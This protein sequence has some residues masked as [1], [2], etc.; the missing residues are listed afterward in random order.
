MQLLRQ[1]T[2]RCEAKWEEEEEGGGRGWFFVHASVCTVAAGG[3]DGGEFPLR[4]PFPFWR[5]AM[6]PGLGAKGPPPPPPPSNYSLF[7]PVGSK[8]HDH[9]YFGKEER[10]PFSHLLSCWGWDL[11]SPFPVLGKKGGVGMP[12]SCMVFRL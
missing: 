4:F 11:D 1:P 9:L 10:H 2:R 7:S 6:W 8:Q 12:R 3:G 5:R